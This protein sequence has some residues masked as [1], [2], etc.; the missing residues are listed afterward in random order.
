MSKKA[1]GDR[2][3]NARPSFKNLGLIGSQKPGFLRQ[4]CVVINS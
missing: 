2:K 1:R 3:K 4:S